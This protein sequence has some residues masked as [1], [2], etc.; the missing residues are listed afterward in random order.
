MI[1]IDFDALSEEIIH[2]LEKEQSVVLATSS[3]DKVTARTMCH[4]NDGLDIYFGTNNKS[5]KYEQMNINPQVALAVGNMQIEAIATIC[6]HPS[7]NPEFKNIYN[8][9]FPHLAGLYPPHEDD[10]VIKCTPTKI[11]LFKYDGKPF[12]DILYPDQKKACRE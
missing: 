6:G 1:A 4:V 7:N 2:I 3:D 10:V 8:A 5:R 11:T 12:W 9:K